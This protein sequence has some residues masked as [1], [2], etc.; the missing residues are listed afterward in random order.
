MTHTVSTASGL[1]ITRWLLGKRVGL[2]NSP[3]PSWQLFIHFF[4]EGEQLLDARA[5]L[6]ALEMRDDV[7]K[8]ENKIAAV[9][10]NNSQFRPDHHH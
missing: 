9:I 4:L 5:L 10:R 2:R 6:H 3:G 8:D 1:E 7:R